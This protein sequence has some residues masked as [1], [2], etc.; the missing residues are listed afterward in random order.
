MSADDQTAAAIE[1]LGRA[2]DRLEEALR[3]APD[4]P[5]A[6]DGTIQ[7]FEFAFE[8]FWKATKRSLAHEGIDVATPRETLRAAYKIGW[9]EDEA[10][11]L[12]MLDDRNMSSHVYDEVMAK[13]IYENIGRNAPALRRGAA[14][15]TR[16]SAQ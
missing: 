5:L 1:R 7:R 15:L 16:R 9:L 2:I 12:G 8:L 11:W 3:I 4:Q 10:T 6:I 14:V 13:R